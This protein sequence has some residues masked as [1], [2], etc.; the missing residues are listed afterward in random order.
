MS[1]PI[2]QRQV[3]RELDRLG[4]ANNHYDNIVS[5][6]QPPQETPHENGLHVRCPDCGLEREFTREH[7]FRTRG[8]TAIRA[9]LRWRRSVL[10]QFKAA[11]VFNRCRA[12]RAK[13][14]L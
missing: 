4:T 13:G 11:H 6:R 9:A 3:D 10:D 12:L 1:I 14:L 2:W 8:F 7:L 5:C